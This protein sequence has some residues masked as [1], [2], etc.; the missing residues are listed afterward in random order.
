MRRFLSR[1]SRS[2]YR[3]ACP[4]PARLSRPSLEPLEDR[5]AP[6]TFTVRP[7]VA[8]GARGSLRAA[9]IAANGNGQN[10]VIKLKAGT[11]TLAV[12]NAT[13]Q[14]NAAAQ[15]DLDLTEPNRSVT[16]KGAGTGQTIISAAA[17][18]RVFQVMNDVTANFSNLTIMRGQAQDNGT[19]GAAFNTTDARGGGILNGGGHVTLNK[20]HVAFSSA[21]A[22]TVGR[23]GAQA[24]GGG[25]YS[26]GGS[27]TLLN[28][29]IQTNNA[30]GGA[31]ANFGGGADG[32]DGG[33]AQGG[34]VYAIGSTV[35]VSNSAFV[36]N[37][38][39]GGLGGTGGSTGASS[40]GPVNIAGAG[41]AGGLAQGG[42]LY[43]AVGKVTV[44]TT[45]FEANAAT[46]GQGSGAG[47]GGQQNG[48]VGGYGGPGGAGGLAQGGGLFMA[49]GTVT[50][51]R[52][53]LAGNRA[54]G[55]NGGNGGAGG[56]SE[57]F[58]GDGGN[59]GAGGAAQGGGLAAADGT[60]TLSNSTVSGNTTRGGTG[61]QGGSNGARIAGGRAGT[62]GR[63]GNG[64][65]SQGG[66]LFVGAATANLRNSTVAFNDSD[67]SLGGARGV[68]VEGQFFGFEGRGQAGQGGAV[69]TTAGLVNAVSTIFSNNSAAGGTHQEVSG[70]FATALN[71][72]LSDGTG[73]NLAAANPDANGNKV[74]TA[75]ARLSAGL[76][77][78]ARNGGPTQTHALE[79][80][81][82]A[83]NAGAN[84]DRLTTD[85]RD[86]ASRGVRGIADIGAFETGAKRRRR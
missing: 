40:S 62:I 53:T 26:S 82:P 23:N 66:G 4:K 42:G 70:S 60:L 61:G 75:A 6:A 56:A 74:G 83:I 58:G 81:S 25:I 11:Y 52:S 37:N 15:G 78:L 63:G 9:I 34:G 10:D 8:D 57:S 46:A 44:A 28:S 32:G 41:G 51:S 20:V 54:R 18:D 77:P 35:S 38:A 7:N 17:I 33:L 45:S 85:Q 48:L 43:T 22:G 31:G 65:A 3:T 13:G 84:P 76:L 79:A 36:A 30:F 72:L 64:G 50:I 47:N 67:N 27:L 14:E 69:F 12:A 16:L 71:N 24:Q 21:L 2:K 59:G 68:P 80:N 49:S 39:L 55:G 5:L 86:F 73:S 19:Q 29:S 1:R